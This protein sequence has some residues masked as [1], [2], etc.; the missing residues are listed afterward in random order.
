V[1]DTCSAA[2]IRVDGGGGG[3]RK[4]FRRHVLSLSSGLIGIDPD[5][6]D[7]VGLLNISVLV[8]TEVAGS[9]TTF[10]FM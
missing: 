10:Q 1:S 5:D 6:R 9:A 3:E 2:V 4:T 8:F 7:R